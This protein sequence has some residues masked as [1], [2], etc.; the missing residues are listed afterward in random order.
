MIR[1]A[2]LP[3]VF[4]PLSDTWMLAAAARR[5]PRLRGGR[6]LDL[7]TGSGAVA[8]SAAL[9]GA[10]SVTAVDVSRR[11]VWTVRLNARLN[12]VRVRALCGDLLAAV[13]DE[14]FDV[15][16]ANPPYLPAEEG[17]LPA[18]GAARHTEAGQTGRAV[19]DRIIA[20]APAHL[21]PGGILLVIHS[22]VNSEEATLDRMRRAGLEAVVVERHRGPLGPLLTARAP[23][24]EARGLLAPGERD[25]DILVVRGTA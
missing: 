8:I 16:C 19:L 6:V 13:G 15:I 25:E 7:C 1:I 14:R 18:R 23:M 3:G 12:G 22:S 17:E 4:R 9:A 20:E 5:Q 24:L 21:L 10:R 2:R 11:A